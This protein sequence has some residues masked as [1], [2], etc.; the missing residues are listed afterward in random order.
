V[1]TNMRNAVEQAAYEVGL[2]TAKYE[3]LITSGTAVRTLTH[4]ELDMVAGSMPGPVGSSPGNGTR[5]R[6]GRKAKAGPVGAPKTT[7]VSRDVKTAPVPR[8]KGVKDA[9]VSLMSGNPDGLTQAKLVEL[10]GFKDA[11]VAGTLQKLQK[12]GLVSRDGRVWTY[13]R[14]SS[15]LEAQ[16]DIGNSETEHPDAN[17]Y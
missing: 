7:T 12:D 8:A 6:P 14:G 10:T 11:S 16:H 4:A 3:M 13:M 5:W 15:A 1:T 9:I 2:A 17:A